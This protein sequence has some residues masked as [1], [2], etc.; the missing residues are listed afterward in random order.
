VA[1]LNVAVQI[2]GKDA[3]SGPIGAVQKALHGLEGAAGAPLKAIGSL[4]NALGAI[5]LAAGGITALTGAAQGLGSALGVGLASN[6]ENVRAQL[7]AFTKSGEAADAILAQINKEAAATPFTFQEMAKATA[8]L[9]PASKQA[10]VGLMELVK[11]AEI[12]AALNPSEGLTGAAF[13][14]RE[15]L[16][17]DFV[18]IVERFNL[19]RS[20]INAL[21][22]EGVPALEIVSRALQGMGADMS[23][24]TNLAGTTSG[25][26]S[27]FQDAIDQLRV[28]AGKPILEAL[29]RAMD[30][31]SAAIAENEPALREFAQLVGDFFYQAITQGVDALGALVGAF[32]RFQPVAREVGN[33]LTAL[34]HGDM[35]NFANGLNRLVQGALADVSSRFDA[36]APTGERLGQLFAWIGERVQDFSPALG[37]AAR[38]ASETDGALARLADV[39]N[40]LSGAVEGAIKLFQDGNPAMA[41]LIGTATSGIAAFGLFRAGMLAVTAATTIQTAATWAATAAQGALNIALTANPIGI[42]VVAIAGL[43]AAI[44]YLWNTNEAFRDSVTKVWMGLTTIAAHIK[45]AIV[46]KFNEIAAFF[47]SL[48]ERFRADAVRTGLAVVQGFVDGLN[49]ARVMAAGFALGRAAFEAAKQAIQAGSPSKLFM[50]LGEDVVAGFALGITENLSPVERAAA[51]MTEKLEDA[52]REHH[53]R[54]ARLQED[55]GQAKGEARKNIL[56]R[57]QRAEEDHQ[58][59]VEQINESGAARIVQLE[60]EQ[61]RNRADA[62]RDL[63][64]GLDDLEADVQ[65]R[66][67]A[68]GTR[69]AEGLA[70]ASADAARAIQDTMKRAADQWQS[71]TESLAL[72]RI[73]RG[74]RDTFGAGQD[75]QAREFRERREDAEAEYRWLRDK[76]KAQLRF[77]VDLAKAETKEKREQV[78]QRLT[79][80]TQAADRAFEQAKKDLARRRQLDQEERDFRQGQERARRAFDDTLEDEALTRQLNRITE[81]RDARVRELGAALG[82]KQRKL[83]EDAARERTLLDRVYADRIGDLKS[84]FLDKVGPLTETEYAKII[85]LLDTITAKA[86]GAAAAITAIPAAAPRGGNAGGDGTEAETGRSAVEQWWAD[87]NFRRNMAESAAVLGSSTAAR[88]ATWDP[89]LS[90]PGTGRQRGGVQYL[91]TGGFVSGP[92]GMPMPAVVHGGELVLTPNQQRGLGVDYDQFAAAVVRALASAHFVVSVDQVHNA[93]LLKAR[94]N[95]RGLGLG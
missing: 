1:D 37:G 87:E 67:E 23:L 22:A 66:A 40:D 13:A 7:L 28:V 42:V 44:A 81:E 30:R 35:E 60:R 58:R 16:S 50:E 9:L 59:R 62:F 89:S 20:A 68:I 39:V 73:I 24:V 71:A 55:A 31:V 92:E 83:E 14:L 70:T 3:A 95:G 63:M 91:Q 79:E 26:L 90:E 49:P 45:D 25:R 10:G 34:V 65:E 77:D 15:A 11:Q 94:T 52:E 47:A 41:L 93:L 38:V 32:Q 88:A 5:G 85:G 56:E 84:K 33:T 78:W 43:A 29:G 19:P 64:R 21:K 61:A 6:M 76:E 8:S 27:T 46:A 80:E 82:E 54:I 69:L 51:E 17:G 2:T 4:T 75:A 74:R 57:I 48:P 53:I 12:L 36:F 86:V 18:S 72:S